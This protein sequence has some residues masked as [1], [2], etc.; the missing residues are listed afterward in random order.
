MIDLK[1]ESLTIVAAIALNLNLRTVTESA[2]FHE[3]LN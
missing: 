3:A 1:L 2:R